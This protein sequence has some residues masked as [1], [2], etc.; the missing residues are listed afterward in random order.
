MTQISNWEAALWLYAFLYLASLGSVIWMTFMATVFGRAVRKVQIGNIIRLTARKQDPEIVIGLVP[1]SA[2]L[3]LKD[4]ADGEAPK[5]PFGERAASGFGQLILPLAFAAVVIGA[6]RVAIVFLETAKTYFVAGLSPL[7]GAPEA[8]TAFWTHM[9]TAP[10]SAIA[11]A[12][13][14]YAFINGMFHIWES[15]FRLS[16]DTDGSFWDKA[17]NTVAAIPLFFLLGWA[18][19]LVKAFF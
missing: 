17:R 4:T 18:V 3:Q 9:K 5:R 8:L 12:A 1:M 11:N 10:M 13:I 14:F 7:S 19:G 2:Y 15:S 16:D 6:G